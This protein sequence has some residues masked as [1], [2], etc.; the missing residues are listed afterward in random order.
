MCSKCS[1]ELCIAG[2]V[3][4]CTKLQLLTLMFIG[5]A[6]GARMCTG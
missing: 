5:V 1:Q 2:G 6:L 4:G 3:L